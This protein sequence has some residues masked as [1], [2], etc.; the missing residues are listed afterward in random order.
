M[1]ILRFLPPVSAFFFGISFLDLF[2]GGDYNKRQ[3]GS[4]FVTD[5]IRGIPRGSKERKEPTV[6]AKRS[7]DFCA[8]FVFRRKI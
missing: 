5:G 4:F 2:F 1:F 8:L 6:W 7:W 3:K